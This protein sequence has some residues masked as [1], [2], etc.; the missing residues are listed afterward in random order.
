G[1]GGPSAA[2]TGAGDP[3]QRVERHVRLRDGWLTGERRSALVDGDRCIRGLGPGPDGF[4]RWA[5]NDVDD[6][7]VA[8]RHCAV[9]GSGGAGPTPRSG[10][11]SESV[12]RP[13][14]ASL[15]RRGSDP[16]RECGPHRSCARGSCSL[17]SG[18][19]RTEHLDVGRNPPG[20]TDALS[21]SS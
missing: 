12:V 2:A 7:T 11:R 14:D 6:P 4:D 21:W 10:G 17:G 9:G 18:G 15:V 8:R 5:T 19:G 16:S 3:S 1:G 13:R 20:G